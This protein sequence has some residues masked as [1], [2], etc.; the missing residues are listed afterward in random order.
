MEG[1]QEEVDTFT[2]EVIS[3][4]VGHDT[5]S[6]SMNWFLHLMG[7]HPQIQAKVHKEIDE[8][9]GEED[10]P[11]T[12]EDLGNLRYL[13]ACLKE[14]LRLFPSVPIIARL[15]TEDTKIKDRILPKGMGV[16]ISP[17]MVHRDPKYWS[18]PE[19]YNPERFI[20]SDFK[21][22]YSY[23]PF[24]AGARNCIGQRFAMMEEKCVLA[25]LLRRL[26]IKSKLRTDQMRV[27][28]ELVIRPMLGNYIRFEKRSYGDYVQIA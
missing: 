9:L 6:A 15:L 26:K 25:T 23:I 1:V 14:A 7:V 8:I 18:D 4:Y 21:Q 28:A 13:E 20:D 5:T 12:Y 11:I 10:R 16:V 3:C 24:S 17:S 2:F 27:S 19:V 22:P